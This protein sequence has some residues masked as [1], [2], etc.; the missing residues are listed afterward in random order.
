M[1][2]DRFSGEGLTLWGRAAFLPGSIASTI[3]TII[4]GAVSA[5][6]T[7]AGG[8]YAAQAGQME[9]TAAYAKADEQEFEAKQVDENSSQVLASAQRAA[10]D[11][12][13]RTRLAIS[14]SRATSAGSGVDAGVGSAVTNQGELAKRG[15]YNA[16]MDMFNGESARTALQNRAAGI[17]FGEQITRYGGDVAEVEGK[18]K[19]V[20]SKYAAAGTLAG[21][22]GSV[23]KTVGSSFY[24]QSFR[25]S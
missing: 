6:G 4:G 22:A 8:N 7:L 25:G 18:Q 24:P 2:N 14:T 23:I 5:E 13:Q 21:T 9:K 20:L 15:S 3:P 19:Q 11:T 10:L 12:A 17:R 1:W 16:L